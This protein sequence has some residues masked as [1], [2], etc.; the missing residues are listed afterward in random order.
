MRQVI[1]KRGF[2]LVELLVVVLILGALSAI[3]L[4]RIV[5][6]ADTAKEKACQSNIDIINTQAELYNAMT[7]GYPK[8]I[9]TLTKDA[10]YFPDGAP[11]CALGG[12]YSLNSSYRAVCS[13]SGSSADVKPKDTKTTKTPPVAKP[14]Q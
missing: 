7:D 13:H 4:P 1:R 14:Y 9:D 12:K 10:D 2:T 8:N 11:V 6:S 3:A 5:A